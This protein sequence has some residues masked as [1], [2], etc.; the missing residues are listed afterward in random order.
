MSDP[1]PN[2]PAVPPIVA[3]AQAFLNWAYEYRM[4]NYGDPPPPVDPL[5]PAER[6]TYEA[7]LEVL[8]NYFSG[9]NDYAPRNHHTPA[10]IPISEGPIFSAVPVQ[11]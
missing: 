11:P 2:P 9:E 3:A 10:T 8:R 5:D 7:A 4:K 1:N 6:R